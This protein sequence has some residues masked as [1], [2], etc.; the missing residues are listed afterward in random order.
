MVRG[1]ELHGQFQVWYWKGWEKRLEDLGLSLSLD[2]SVEITNK[3]ETLT[4]RETK[5]PVE[6]WGAISWGRARN[7][8]IW[9]KW[10]WKSWKLGVSIEAVVVSPITEKGFGFVDGKMQGMISIEVILTTLQA[11]HPQA[12]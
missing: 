3:K 6:V 10:N 9:L 2:F 5:K 8:H 11:G 4:L 7:G 12:L 1:N